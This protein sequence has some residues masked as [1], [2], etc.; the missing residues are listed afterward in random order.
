MKN[1]S[2]FLVIGTLIPAVLSLVLFWPKR[3][4]WAARDAMGLALIVVFS[5][6]LS[7]ARLLGFEVAVGFRLTVAFAV[8]AFVWIRLIYLLKL[9]GK[10]QHG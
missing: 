8:L 7:L 1:L 5:Y 10:E 4:T 2:L 9:K 3:W 6:S